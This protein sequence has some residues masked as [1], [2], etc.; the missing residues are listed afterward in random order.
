VA[1]NQKGR[2]GPKHP[3]KTKSTVSPT[4][5]T[6]QKV[7]SPQRPPPPGIK[8]MATNQNPIPFRAQRVPLSAPS[9]PPLRA[10]GGGDT[11]WHKAPPQ[12]PP[13]PAT[14]PM[15]NGQSNEASLVI[16]QSVVVGKSNSLRNRNRAQNE[17]SR[18]LNAL[19][20]FNYTQS[21]QRR[22][23]RAPRAEPTV[24]REREQPI[25]KRGSLRKHQALFKEPDD[26]M[27]GALNGNQSK[28]HP[29]T[30]SEQK[31][32]LNRNATAFVPPN[33]KHRYDSRG[34]LRETKREPTRSVRSVEGLSVSDLYGPPKLAANQKRASPPKLQYGDPIYHVPD[35]IL[36]SPPND[37]YHRIQLRYP[38]NYSASMSP[39]N[40]WRRDVVGGDEVLHEEEQS[41]LCSPN[42]FAVDLASLGYNRSPSRPQHDDNDGAI[43]LPHEFAPKTDM[44][45]SIE[46]SLN[47]MLEDDD[48]IHATDLFASA[49]RKRKKKKKERTPKRP[50]KR[51]VADTVSPRLSELF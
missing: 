26:R 28:A 5:A 32:I 49:H 6:N 7:V 46:H 36:T 13:S 18:A 10:P 42:G 22:Q 9:V 35:G 44:E 12:K 45:F 39:P 1:T 19:K 15:D 4:K 16:P 50:T 11:V 23:S 29:L 43:P 31:S 37:H 3:A 24:R 34:E 17:S 38:D 41:A 21:P 48:L 47:A 14:K 27:S 40:Q 33:M 51:S 25:N 20:K 2:R 8:L 30:A